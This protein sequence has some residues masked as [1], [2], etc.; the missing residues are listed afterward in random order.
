MPGP[1]IVGGGPAGA[2]AAIA[3]AR[4]GRGVTLIERTAG[5]TDKVCG[6]FLSAE[7]IE[8]IGALGVDAAALSP[9][10]IR[11]VRLIHGDRAATAALPFPALGLTRRVLDEALLQQ[12]M[13]SGA[14]VLRGHA[15]RGIEPSGGALRIRCGSLG[16]LN[17]DAV[18][19]ATGKHDLRGAARS[20]RGSGLVGMKM[21][22]ALDP[23]Q[24]ISLHG[25][26][27]L[28][29]F[30]GGYAGLQLVECDRAVLCALVPGTRLRAADGQW[31]RLLDR[32]MHD[33]PHLARRL[34]SAQPL[35]ERPLAVA[36]LPY[37][38]T[39]ASERQNRRGLFR[40]GDQATVIASLTGD[41]V[42]LALSSAALACR[43]W[44]AGDNADAGAYH[45]AWAQR[46]AAQ[47]R[48]ASLIHRTCLVPAAQPW[49]LR[50]CRSWPRIM[51][52]AAS[53]TRLRGNFCHPFDA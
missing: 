2:A 26:I 49:L 34:A 13:V 29:L 5:A 19:L 12:A 9:S 15:V 48:M 10:R 35:L 20:G 51:R 11:A 37:G 1:V 14:T 4:A 18:F 7:A 41:G 24:R 22:Y 30:A 16:R 17:A 50:L 38:Y 25:H 23:A 44:L 28:I 43:I 33:C 42:A 45:R 39:S 27:E 47:M 31:D 3:L 32:L 53:R 40:L 46:T 52:L 36:G 21:Y 8:A 6:D